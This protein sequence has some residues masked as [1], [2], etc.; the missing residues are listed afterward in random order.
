MFINKWYIF[1]QGENDGILA[2]A[3][4]EGYVSL[5]L[6]YNVAVDIATN[7]VYKS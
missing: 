1:E 5:R 7:K 2:T 4:M 3:E 6:K